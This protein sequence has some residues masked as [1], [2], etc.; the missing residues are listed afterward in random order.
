MAFFGGGDHDLKPVQPAPMPV[1]LA[2]TRLF[3]EWTRM[4]PQKL[5]NYHRALFNALFQILFW[6]PVLLFRQ[7]RAASKRESTAMVW[8]VAE[9]GLS[10][11]RSGRIGCHAASWDNSRSEEQPEIQ[12]RTLPNPLPAG[13]GGLFAANCSANAAT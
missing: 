13:Q 11:I 1:K 10:S 9:R 4:T 12:I 7:S 6:T 5:P 8:F 2:S 3:H